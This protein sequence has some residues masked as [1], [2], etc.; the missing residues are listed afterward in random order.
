MTEGQLAS[1]TEIRAAAKNLPRVVR[2]TPMLPV[3][4]RAEEV[5]NEALL[6][7]AENLQVTGAYKVRAAFT[8]V[9]DLSPTQREKGIV[10][11]LSGKF[12]QGFSYVGSL[13]RIKVSV[14]ML[15]RTAPLR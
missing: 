11:A 9:N 5:G 4:Y 7:K 10:I 3:A 8:L 2:R 6:V 15:D 12:A 13:S 1:L 14:V